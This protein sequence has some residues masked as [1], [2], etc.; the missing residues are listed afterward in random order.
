[1]P[2]LYKLNTNHPRRVGLR[3]IDYDMESLHAQTKPK[4]P[5][6][7]INAPPLSS[8]DEDEE[9]GG[10]DLGIMSEDNLLTAGN[11]ERKEGATSVPDFHNEPSNIP[12]G[13]YTVKRRS[14]GRN[15]S[16]GSQKRKN[17]EK[18]ESE[19]NVWD[20]GDAQTKSSQRKKA[21]LGPSLNIHKGLVKPRT[22][23]SKNASVKKDRVPGQFI[24]PDLE[25]VLNSGMLIKMLCHGNLLM[26]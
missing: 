9:T 12:H 18:S 5:D 24:K 20:M 11:G 21:K 10:N 19:E 14:S 23:Q 6:V 16:Q 26:S 4:L 22:Y 3:A 25:H 17:T 8:S 15:S 7:D 2:G 1:M 13:T